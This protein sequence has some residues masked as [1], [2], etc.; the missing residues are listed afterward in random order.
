MGGANVGSKRGPAPERAW[1]EGPARGRCRC[2]P[3]CTAILPPRDNRE[4]EPRAG[5]ALRAAVAEP[6]PR[7]LPHLGGRGGGEGS[8]PFGPPPTAFYSMLL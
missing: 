4:G 2:H 5:R 1:A 6:V 3:R 8:A 7:R